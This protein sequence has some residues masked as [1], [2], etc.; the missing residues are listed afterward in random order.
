MAILLTGCAGTR[1]GP[2]LEEESSSVT[3]FGSLREVPPPDGAWRPQ[4]VSW[5]PEESGAPRRVEELLELCSRYFQ[6]GSG[7]DGMLEL[8]MALSEGQR[9]PLLLL[10]LGL[11]YLGAGQG[12][13]DLLP[14]EGPAADVGDWPRNRIRLLERAETLLTEA[15]AGRPQDAAVDYLLADVWRAR[16]D[17]RKADEFLFQGAAKCTSG[18]GFDILAFYRQ[19]FRHPGKYLGGPGPDYPAAALEQG[20][21]GEVVLDLLISPL[22]EVRQ[23]DIVSAPER[24]LARAAALSLSEGQ[25]QPASI[26]KYPVWSW[27]RVNT[28]F[29]LAP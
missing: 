5:C 10:T 17:F 9:H 20:I 1:P 16:E 18:R 22:G 7:T 19:L 2:G 14:P 6:E 29:S 27:L 4:V 8:E 28:S 12:D 23:A 3:V 21:S 25:W 15:R 11:L 24:S 13:P 26:G